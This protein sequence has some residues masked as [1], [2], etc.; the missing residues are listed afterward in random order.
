MGERSDK[1]SAPGSARIGPAHVDAEQSTVLPGG[2]TTDASTEDSS[3]DP[4][5][6][7]V[8]ATPGGETARLVPGTV[9]GDGFRIEGRLGA[10]GMG[11]VYLARDLSLD[12]PVAVKVHRGGTG[13]DRLTREATAMARLAHPNVVT[14]HAVGQYRGDVFVAMEYLAGGTLRDW[15][16]AAPR[17]WRDVLARCRAAGEGLAAAHAAGLVH[18]DFKPDN[19]LFTEAGV[20]KVGDFG[21]ARAQGDASASQPELAVADAHVTPSERPDFISDRLTRTGA[22][23]GTPAYMAPEQFRG[24]IDARADQFALAVVVWEALFGKRPYAGKDAAALELAV[25]AGPPSTPKGGRVPPAVTAVVRR[26]LAPDPAQR[27]ASVRAFLDALDHAAG[28]RRRLAWLGGG[29]AV[30]AAGIA[31]ALLGRMRSPADPCR[32]AAAR[33]DRLVPGLLLARVDAA[34]DVAPGLDAARARR[35]VAQLVDGLRTAATT[36]CAA[37][38]RERSMAP[39]LGAKSMACVEHRARVTAVILDDAALLARDPAAYL[40]RLRGAP[41]TSACL[42]PVALAANPALPVADAAVARADLELAALDLEV[43]QLDEAAE[44]IDQATGK[45]SAD[46]AVIALAASV[47]GQLAVARG[48]FDAAERLLTDAYYGGQAVDD[49]EVYLPALAALVRLA[50][51]VQADPRKAAPWVRAA[52]A[53]V[54]RDRRRAPAQVA[55]VMLALVAVD[56]R[57]GDGAG[58]VRWAESARALIGPGADAFTQLAIEQALSSATAAAG[59]LRAAVTHAQAAVAACVDALGAAHPS[60]VS[61][62]ADLA[63]ALV[64]DDREVEAVVEAR[65]A[66]AALATS[67][68]TTLSDRA[69]ALLSIGAV[70][71]DEPADRAAAAAGFAEARDLLVALHGPNHPDVATAEQ[72]LAVVAM[73]RRAWP[74]AEAALARAVEIQERYLGRDHVDVAATLFNLATTRLRRGELEAALVDAERVVVTLSAAA[75]T[76]SR[77]AYAL[78]LQAE[79]LIRSGRLVEGAEVARRGL[80]LANQLDGPA[81]FDLSIEVARADIAAGRGLREAARLLAEARPQFAKFP[82]TFAWQLQEIETLLARLQ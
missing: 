15:L 4:L 73:K 59:D 66:R 35:R 53:A 79:I 29:A 76:S 70:L 77:M 78:R 18:R 27:F 48:D 47:R 21:L 80:A 55:S 26:A 3:L 30:V 62:R 34:L 60:C 68:G 40:R 46:R 81:Y 63:T 57:Q 64:D 49:A 52:E 42:D 36:S 50:G 39:E 10:G 72:D 65:A 37:T 20:P 13:A 58:A 14:V 11:V 43:D 19:V 74:A 38:A 44:L 54:D 24:S 23:V 31:V 32:A 75:P 22:A 6:A 61:H 17:S 82:E 5:L 9:L 56:E 41:T 51:D 45:V 1:P 2:L 67:R 71:L 16:R 28:A 7:A 25:S 12:R 8:A 69:T 33:V